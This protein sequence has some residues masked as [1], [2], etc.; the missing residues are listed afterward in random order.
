MVKQ[1]KGSMSQEF[2]IAARAVYAPPTR[3]AIV[4]VA[5][6]IEW[7]VI[8][9]RD[10]RVVYQSLTFDVAVAKVSRI[11]RVAQTIPRIPRENRP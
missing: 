10:G 4:P 3:G 8:R 6:H 1:A 5:H 7:E 2:E 11:N 9:V